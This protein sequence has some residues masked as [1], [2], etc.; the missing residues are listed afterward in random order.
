MLGLV[1]EH[2]KDER[3]EMKRRMKR[4]WL[5]LLL[6]A[7]QPALA[8]P[9]PAPTDP[10][11]GQV[12]VGY[13]ATSGNTNSTNANATF[14]LLYTLERWVHDFDATAV[15]ASTED[16][17]TAEAYSAKYE[18]RRSF[19][20]GKRYLFASLDWQRDRFSAYDEQVSEAVGYGRTLLSRGRQAMHGEIGVGARQSRLIDLTEESEAILHTALD[21]EFTMSETTAFKQDF[22]VES[23]SSNT[24]FESISALRARLIGKV[25]LVLSYRV[26]AN[27][28][29]PPGVVASDRFTSIALEYAF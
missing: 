21:Y 6:A 22:V 12:A 1:T 11:T 25:G 29:V 2:P 19:G 7:A 10:L 16:V 3:T 20:D 5:G 8:Q 15:S 13:L 18:G 24:T 27:S 4:R 14:A 17:T 9:P 26:K 28:D 23:G